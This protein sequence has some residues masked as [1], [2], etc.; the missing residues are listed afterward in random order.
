MKTHENLGLF[1]SDQFSNAKGTAASED[2]I[3]GFAIHSNGHQTP[4]PDLSQ[5][6]ASERVCFLSLIHR[7]LWVSTVCR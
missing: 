6:A 4:F 2:V 5:N 1:Q 7:C 3:G